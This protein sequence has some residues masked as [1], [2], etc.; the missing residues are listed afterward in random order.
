MWNEWPQSGSTDGDA[1]YQ[2]A[3]AH[4]QAGQPVKAMR[5]I[6]TA[7]HSKRATPSTLAWRQ[8]LQQI[9]AALQIGR[10]PYLLYPA[11]VRTKEGTLWGYIDDSGRFALPPQFELAEPFQ[12]NGLAIVHVKKG[13]GLINLSGQFVVQPVY[14]SISPFAEGRAAVIVGDQGFHVIDERGRILTRKAYSYIGTYHQGRAVYADTVDGKYLYGYLDLQG[15]EVIPAQ[16]QSANDFSERLAVVQLQENQFA[17]IGPGGERRQTFPYYQV[18]SVGNGLLPL[19]RTA[20][21][22]FGYM[23]TQ[24]KVVIPPRFTNAQTFVS[25]LAVVDVSEDPVKNQFGLIDTRGTFVLQPAY[26]D[27]RL[28]G[29]NRAAVG[30]AIDPEAPYKGSVYALAATDGRLLTDFRYLEIADF[31]GGVAS[32]TDGKQTYFLDRNGRRAA[33]LPVV[34]G[35][36]T[37]RKEGNLI[38]ADVDQRISYVDTSGRL[39]YAQ[40]TVI[41]LREPY[42]VREEKYAPNK[43]YLVYY[44][45]VEG[46]ANQQAQAQVNQ[47]L[48]QLSQV[49]P[50][51]PD[52]QLES[53]YT[54]DFEMAFFQKQLLQLELNSYD[55]PFGAA[56]GM[57][58][59][60][61]VPIDLV[62]GRIYQ[63]RDLFKPGSD[64][65]KMLSGIVGEQIRT[66]PQYS[67]VFPDSYKGIKPDQ[68]F[69]VT[70]D[71]LHLYFAP[72]EIAPYAAGF[73]TFR[74]PYAQL[75]NIIDVNGAF[76]RSFHP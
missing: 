69:Y 74:I 52:A 73:P 48:R 49:K 3:V 56:H 66:D 4:I 36:G 10:G 28:L 60:I 41:P 45:Q 58:G 2:E 11:A 65:V 72:Y 38:M 17:L 26:N 19:K 16:F 43:D 51:D 27:L 1:L 55:Y 5:V 63:L 9:R 20:Q 40:N 68:P 6:E 31:R 75:M 67:Y 62:S 14:S 53:S 21:E 46:M 12:P 39:V 61:Y 57:P 24:G 33:N 34:A 54:A 23:D 50:V 15:R 64:Y 70:A 29:E 22:K 8:L 47:R 59:L 13:V 37:L 35:R 32:V 71:A 76:W 42:R 44:P 18:G 25:G 7:L 30:K